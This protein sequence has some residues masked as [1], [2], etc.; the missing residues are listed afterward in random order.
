MRYS[1]RRRAVAVAIGAPRGRRRCAWV[2]RPL[3]RFM[4][5]QR[6]LLLLLLPLACLCAAEADMVTLTDLK[7]GITGFRYLWHVP[8][9]T[10]TRLPSWSPTETEAPLS[11]H[12]ATKAAL[13]EVRRHF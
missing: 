9:A 12:K 13:A 1:E 7:D 4:N 2:V 3:E 11:P 10:L 5:T 8:R 6:L